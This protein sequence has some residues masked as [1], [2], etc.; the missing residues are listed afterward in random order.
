ML[1]RK[2][3]YAK[4]LMPLSRLYGIVVWLRN[5]LFDYNIIKS[6][7]Y[8]IPIIC[9]GNISVGGTGKTPHVEY[10]L[11]LISKEKKVAVV[12]RGYKR[13]TK[14]LV[15][16]NKK[17]TSREIGDEPYQI[18]KKFP[19]VK[20]VVDG[21]RRRAIDYLLSL[22]QGKRPD[23]IVMDDGFQHRYVKPSFSIVLQNYDSPF[24]NAELLPYGDMRENVKAIYRADCIIVTKCPDDLKPMAYRIVERELNLYPHQSMFFSKIKYCEP[25]QMDCFFDHD[26]ISPIIPDHSKVILLAGIANPDPM[27]EYLDRKY[28]V[29]C[30]LIFEDHKY[31]NQQ[32]IRYI[33]DAYHDCKR[34]KQNLY[35]ITTEKDLVRINEVRDMIDQEILKYIYYLP[36]ETEIIFDR[37]N[38]D[39][40]IK[41][42]SSSQSLKNI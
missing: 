20:V 13:K 19:N 23:V 2:G 15:V 32:N 39:K 36:I 29:E 41:F 8:D 25:K 6:K 27:I 17:T 30:E 42:K 4:L 11:G 37:Y 1:I 7:T 9:V 24:N 34:E 5:S 33:E 14:G 40:L 10:I 22:E 35:I 3:K 31:F 38:F 18:K 12:S 28:K 26:M 21:N 16:A